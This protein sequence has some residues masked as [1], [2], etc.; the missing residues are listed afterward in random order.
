MTIEDRMFG[1]RWKLKQCTSLK[2]VA[3]YNCTGPPRF[4]LDSQV[5]VMMTMVYVDLLHHL[6][7]F[8]Q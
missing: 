1:R 6:Q 7:N 3:R 8:W 4:L 2:E 5:L